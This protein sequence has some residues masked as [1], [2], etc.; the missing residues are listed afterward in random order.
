MWNCLRNSQ[1]NQQMD[2]GNLQNK[3]ILHSYSYHS[4]YN[5]QAGGMS[6]F[7]FS[8]LSLHQPV[9][10][11]M[12]SKK[13]FLKSL[14]KIFMQVNHYDFVA[15]HSTGKYSEGLRVLFRVEYCTHI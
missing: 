10:F 6:I 15:L 2:Y 9:R 12:Q 3:E 1:T 7:V 8:I 5:G 14:H 4:A 13:H 11:K